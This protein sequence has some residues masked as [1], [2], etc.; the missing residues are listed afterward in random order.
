MSDFDFPFNNSWSADTVVYIMDHMRPV[1]PNSFDAFDALF[2]V[3]HDL[4]VKSCPENSLDFF[5]VL[6]SYQLYPSVELFMTCLGGHFVPRSLNSRGA[7]QIAAVRLSGFLSSFLRFPCSGKNFDAF[8]AFMQAMPSSPYSSFSAG[9][10]PVVDSD[11]QLMAEDLADL[12]RLISLLAL[13]LCFLHE[14]KDQL[15]RLD[16][17]HVSASMPSEGLA[18]WCYSTPPRLLV[19]SAA[20]EDTL[21]SSASPTLPLALLQLDLSPA[22][23]V[24]PVHALSSPALLQDLYDVFPSAS[25]VVPVVRSRVDAGPSLVPPLGS[26]LSGTSPP[27]TAAFFTSLM[28]NALRGLPALISQIVDSRLSMLAPIVPAPVVVG[29]SPSPVAAVVSAGVDPPGPISAVHR[30][31]SAA[32]PPSLYSLSTSHTLWESDDDSDL[33][34]IGETSSR[35]SRLARELSISEVLELNLHVARLRYPGPLKPE[36][37]IFMFASAVD[38]LHSKTGR[39]FIVGLT[40]DLRSMA[41]RPGEKMSQ[42]QNRLYVLSLSGPNFSVDSGSHVAPNSVL[43]FPFNLVTLNLWISQ[44]IEAFH[45]FALS[46]ANCFSEVEKHDIV[47]FAYSMANSFTLLFRQFLSLG[48][49]DCLGLQKSAA[50]LSLFWHIWNHALLFSDFS[51]ASPAALRKLFEVRYLPYCQSAWTS[52]DFLK[53]ALIMFNFCCPDLTKQH[54]GHAILIP[55]A[56]DPRV[57]TCPCTLPAAAAAAGGG[58]HKSSKHHCY[59]IAGGTNSLYRQYNYAAV[60][61]FNSSVQNR[62]LS[63]KDRDGLMDAYVVANKTMLDTPKYTTPDVRPSGIDSFSGLS[64]LSLEDWYTHLLTHQQLIV[65]PARTVGGYASAGF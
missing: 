24:F 4:F 38:A 31:S 6:Q 28:E 36:Q 58:A 60:K 21:S 29:A 18:V 1:D 63:Q 10:F 62:S 27:I 11:L 13:R 59:P 40:R 64:P 53:H 54:L 34:T 9:A 26:G 30:R 3:Y 14:H 41:L 7:P 61:L 5:A 52:V 32:A 19:W 43:S 25:D 22:Q 17:P 49:K 51:H 48:D 39:N 8:W 47:Q 16:P 46:A 23:P 50:L 2:V 45:V 37:P 20:S 42:S 44:E 35:V 65:R 56:S 57:C 55:S 15:S 12:M 33:S